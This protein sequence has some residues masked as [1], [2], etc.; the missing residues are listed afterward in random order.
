LV[1]DKF[2]YDNLPVNWYMKL[3]LLPLLILVVFLTACQPVKTVPDW[4][5]APWGPFKLVDPPGITNPVLTAADVTDRA[6]Q[7]VADPFLFHEEDSWYMFLEVFNQETGGDIGVA[8]SPDG[9]HWKYDRIVLD[10]P[11][12]LSYPYVFKA[13]GV[14][15]MIPESSQ[16]QDVRVYKAVRFPYEWSYV[17]TI[18]NRHKYVDPSILYSNGRWWLFVSDTENSTL[19][20]FSSKSITGGWEEHPMSPVIH[21]SSRDARPGGRVFVYD[22]DKIIRVAQS[23]GNVLSVRAYQVDVLTTKDFAEHEIMQSP[24]LKPGPNPEEWYAAG[25]HQFD[26]WWTGEKWIVVYD[27]RAM[28][29]VY[30]IGIKDAVKP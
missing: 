16:P 13:D 24:V 29:D 21:N 10:E 5:G 27:G 15:Y 9:Y 23:Y 14:Y 18:L 1:N 2:Y 11:F 30:S 28:D 25:M 8:T 22:Q 19:Y 17:A 7:F 4:A 26:P 6:A 12:H 20:L 3:R